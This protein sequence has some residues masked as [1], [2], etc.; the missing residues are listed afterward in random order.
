[1]LLYYVIVI[2]LAIV[3]ILAYVKGVKVGQAWGTPVMV[4]C[5][6]LIL[7]A[8]GYRVVAGGGEAGGD[9]YKGEK[10]NEARNARMLAEAVRDEITEPVTVVVL[11][12][13]MLAVRDVHRNIKK[14]K[15]RWEAGFQTGLGEGKLASLVVWEQ[16]KGRSSR[17][18]K[19]VATADIAFCPQGDMPDAVGLMDGPALVL[20]Y[21]PAQA[22][23]QTVTEEAV[24]QKISDGMVDAAVISDGKGGLNLIQK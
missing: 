16:R 14:S 15:P 3:L 2:V 10:G 17:L 7:G 23:T 12:P 20:V 22:G 6:L 19:S 24:R 13:P 18:P 5:L 21:Y 8:V 1:M 4:V 11:L 9:P